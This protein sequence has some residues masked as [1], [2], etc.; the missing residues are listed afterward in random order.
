MAIPFEMI[1][2][3]EV[4]IP[5]QS[6]ALEFSCSKRRRWKS[7]FTTSK[8]G[9]ALGY[10]WMKKCLTVERMSWC[11]GGALGVKLALGGKDDRHT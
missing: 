3:H 10:D 8:S 9:N 4:C 1:V 6:L 11:A 2:P 7:Q 5:S